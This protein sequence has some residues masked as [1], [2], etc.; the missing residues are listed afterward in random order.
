MNEAVIYTAVSGTK[1]LSSSTEEGPACAAALLRAPGTAPK[2]GAKVPFKPFA[3]P[4]AKPKPVVKK[5][6]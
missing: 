2:P 1:L 6:G 3:K 4:A 5:A